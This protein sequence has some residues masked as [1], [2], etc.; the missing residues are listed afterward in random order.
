[1]TEH[2]PD[3]VLFLFDQL[4]ADAIGAAGNG[5]VRTPNLDRTAASSVRFVQCVTNAPL[6]RPA[7]ITLMTGQPVHRHRFTTNNR[8]PDPGTTPSHVRR[9]RDERGYHTARRRSPP[10]RCRAGTPSSD[11]SATTRWS[12]PGSTAPPSPPPVSLRHP[13]AVDARER[14]VVLAQDPRPLRGNVGRCS[15]SFR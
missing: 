4:R 9:L 2:P 15:C 3:V 6:C 5:F 1:V 11:G 8:V 7:R 13:Q 12:T 14:P 10:P